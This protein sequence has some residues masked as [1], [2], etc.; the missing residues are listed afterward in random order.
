L[1]TDGFGRIAADDEAIAAASAPELAYRQL[2]RLVLHLGLRS[3]KTSD[4]ERGSRSQARRDPSHLLPPTYFSI[5]FFPAPP[6]VIF[7][8]F[9]SA[10]FGIRS[11]STPFS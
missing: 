2:R 3:S 5:C 10:G 4:E 9:C 11:S 7:F 6:M 1:P 8:G